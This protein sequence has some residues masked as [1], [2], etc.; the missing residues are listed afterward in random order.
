M[1]DLDRVKKR[2]NKMSKKTEKKNENNY[3]DRLIDHIIKEWKKKGTVTNEAST[4]ENIEA[5]LFLMTGYRLKCLIRTIIDIDDMM[6][7]FKEKN[8][9]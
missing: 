5:M 1:T 4:R 3:Y 8:D 9:G 7:K 6:E 2:G